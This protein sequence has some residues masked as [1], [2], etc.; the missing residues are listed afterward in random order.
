MNLRRIGR[1]VRNILRHRQLVL[2]PGPA[3]IFVSNRRLGRGHQLRIQPG[4]NGLPSVRPC[5]P[6]PGMPRRLWRSHNRAGSQSE[7]RDD[8]PLAQPDWRP[9]SFL[10][11]TALG[12][13]GEQFRFFLLLLLLLVTLFVI[14]RLVV[15]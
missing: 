14:L 8:C 2:I 12:N 1:G 10:G 3:K 5:R 9:P 13:I 7:R 15:G 4:M 6:H 11:L